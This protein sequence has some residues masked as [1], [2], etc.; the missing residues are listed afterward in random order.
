MSD[1]DKPPFNELDKVTI[2][3]NDHLGVHYVE[4]CEWY[5]PRPGGAQPYWLVELSA[6]REPIDWSSI[7]EGATGIVTGSRWTGSSKH[8]TLFHPEEY[9]DNGPTS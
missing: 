4:S 9:P 5:V 8:L 2:N 7:P 3:G 6:I 1:I